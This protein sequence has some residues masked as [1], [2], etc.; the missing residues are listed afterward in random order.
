MVDKVFISS[1]ISRW[2]HI[3]ATSYLVGSFIVLR[4]FGPIDHALSEKIRDPSYVHIALTVLLVSGGYNLYLLWSKV[5]S[6]EDAWRKIYKGC[7]Y[8]KIFLG[9]GTF[10]ITS[11]RFGILQEA[12]L[13]VFVIVVLLSGILRCI[14]EKNM[15]VK[16]SRKFE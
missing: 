14:R 7:L 3:L 11:P 8:S 16:E 2:S 15:I 10:I 13:T 1:I 9:L 5:K 6:L 12:S 4:C